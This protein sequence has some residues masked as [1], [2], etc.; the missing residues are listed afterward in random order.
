MKLYT[1]ARRPRFTPS[2]CSSWFRFPLR[3]FSKN[4]RGLHIP[5]TKPSSPLHTKPEGQILTDEPSSL[6]EAGTSSTKCGSRLEPAHKA[7]YLA[8]TLSRANP[9][10]N[11]H[12]VC[13]KIYRCDRWA[14]GWLGEL[15]WCRCRLSRLFATS[16]DPGLCPYIVPQ[17]KVAVASHYP[18]TA[19]GHLGRFNLS[20]TVYY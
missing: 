12:K 6:P 4:D 8:L 3:S 17:L 9:S 15:L 19:T 7:Q 13:A 5:R 1:K 11:S 18:K 2:F 14:L 16:N 10:T 20:H